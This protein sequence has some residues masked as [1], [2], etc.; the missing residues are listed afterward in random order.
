VKHL[1]KS[2]KSPFVIDDFFFYGMLL[3]ILGFFILLTIVV[4]YGTLL[5]PYYTIPIYMALVLIK[6]IPKIVEK[7][8]I[9]RLLYNKKFKHLSKKYKKK[10]FLYDHT[11]Y[12]SYVFEHEL[13]T[14]S[15]ATEVFFFT[16]KNTDFDE[17]YY[18]KDNENFLENLK[19]NNKL[20]KDKGNWLNE[21]PYNYRI[22][23]VLCN[24]KDYEI[25]MLSRNPKLDYTEMCDSFE[26]YYMTKNPA[27]LIYNNL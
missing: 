21:S 5:F 13:I 16:H 1:F 4:L 2:S 26:K 23:I 24:K 19:F 12:S 7:K 25:I 17:L 22:V 3:L 14:R 20:N 11:W 15:M 6:L 8:Q 18:I 10:I 9:L 27:L